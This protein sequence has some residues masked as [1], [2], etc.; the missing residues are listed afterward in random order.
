LDTRILA[1]A[2]DD[3]LMSNWQKTGWP[4]A[5][6]I[7][8]EIAIPA[9]CGAVWGLLAYNQGKTSFES[10][11]T[12]FAAFFFIFFLQGQVLR[13]AKNVSDKQNADEWR[14]SF[15]SIQEGL[16]SLKKA[17]SGNITIN[18]PA[19]ELRVTP[20]PPTA[21]TAPT[22]HSA[23]LFEQARRMFG[24]DFFQ[25]SAIAAAMAFETAARNA[26]ARHGLPPNKPMTE[27]VRQIATLEGN[28]QLEEELLT[29]VRLRN[30]LMHSTSRDPITGDKAQELIDAFERGAKRLDQCWPQ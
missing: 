15:A 7:L 24:S 21:S 5:R 23:D 27:M 4:I 10:A 14:S 22:S 2:E 28:K 3:A 8:G 1:D 29:L 16:N 18:V 20:H 9:A 26:G 19:G 30:S 13:V 6:R 12:G 25:Q 11:S 17:E